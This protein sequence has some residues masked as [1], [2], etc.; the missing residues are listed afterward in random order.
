M[1]SIT[2]I[3]GNTTLEYKFEI[4]IIVIWS[5][6]HPL[7]LMI[8]HVTKDFQVIVGLLTLDRNWNIDPKYKNLF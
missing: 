1:D 5:I 4:C 2:W 3:I 8:F 7:L 6:E